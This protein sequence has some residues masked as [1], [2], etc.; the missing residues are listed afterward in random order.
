LGVEVYLHALLT[1]ALNGYEWSASRSGHFT[2]Q[3]KSPLCPLDR[4]LG[5]PPRK[6]FISVTDTATGIMYNL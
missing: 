4:R 5:G 3:K 6:E 1:S 2:T